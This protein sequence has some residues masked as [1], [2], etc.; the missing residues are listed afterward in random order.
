MQLPWKVFPYLPQ[1]GNRY[2]NPELRLMM[3]FNQRKTFLINIPSRTSDYTV[4]YCGVVNKTFLIGGFFFFHL[5]IDFKVYKQKR[6][7][8]DFF[9]TSLSQYKHYPGNKNSRQSNSLWHLFPIDNKSRRG[10]FYVASPLRG[11]YSTRNNNDQSHA[12]YA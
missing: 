10:R 11:T 6:R 5:S 1:V 3:V 4:L 9:F 7:V 2:R 12:I 8:L